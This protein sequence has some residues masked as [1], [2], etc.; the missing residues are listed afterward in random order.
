[1]PTILSHAV[2]A[3]G[4]F[5]LFYRREVPKGVW[6]LGAV[7]AALPAADVLALSPKPWGSTS[8]WSPPRTV[9]WTP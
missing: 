5:A 6:A 3:L 2:A 1:M 8:L 7:C 9:S 4:L